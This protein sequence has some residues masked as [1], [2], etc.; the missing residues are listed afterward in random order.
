[1]EGKF[2]KFHFVKTNVTM[3]FFSSFLNDPFLSAWTQ[4]S[5]NCSGYKWT[6][7]ES[8]GWWFSHLLKLHIKV[9]CQE[10]NNKHAK[11]GRH[12]WTHIPGEGLIQKL[13]NATDLVSLL[14]WISVFLISFIHACMYARSHNTGPCWSW[15]CNLLPWSLWSSSF[16]SLHRRWSKKWKRT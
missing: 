15:S 12:K 6:D 11:S 1:M 9:Q 8:W 7:F 10:K 3:I 2:F 4:M 5:T 14:I 16:G 13:R